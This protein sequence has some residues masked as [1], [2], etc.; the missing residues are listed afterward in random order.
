MD[1]GTPGE[2]L[3][4]E[5]SMFMKNAMRNVLHGFNGMERTMPQVIAEILMNILQLPFA[6]LYAMM[7]YNPTIAGA[8]KFIY[9]M[10]TWYL[11][12]AVLVFA[13][14]LLENIYKSFFTARLALLGRLRPWGLISA[15]VGVHDTRQNDLNTGIVTRNNNFCVNIVKVPMTGL[16]LQVVIACVID[17]V[18]AAIVSLAWPVT[19]SVFIITTL[20]TCRAPKVFYEYT[21][22]ENNST[23]SGSIHETVQVEYVGPTTVEEPEIP[24]IPEIPETLLRRKPDDEE[25]DDE[26]VLKGEKEEEVEFFEEIE[27][28]DAFPLD[29]K[30]KDEEER[31][32]NGEKED[33]E[34]PVAHE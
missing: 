2:E 34:P 27:E 13:Y 4:Q 12:V 18:V 20:F 19:T 15:L 24:E 1:Y 32:E 9:M 21:V 30:A 3:S 10:F 28:A 16:M 22:I 11:T 33:G 23:Q 5:F 17:L 29:A 6:I 31:E 25:E 14:F 26:S 7:T 8:F